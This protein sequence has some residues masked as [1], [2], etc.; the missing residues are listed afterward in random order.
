MAG[1]IS[2]AQANAVID[3]LFGASAAA[4]WL[5]IMVSAP[6]GDGSGGVEVT[7]G[8]YAR[9]AFTDNATTW[10]AAAARQ[11]KNGI[12]FTFPAPTADWG[13]NMW[14]LGVYD[15][16]TGGVPKGFFKFSTP[17]TILNGYPAFVV[18]AD[19]V[20]AGVFT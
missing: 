20:T 5:A 11:K 13:T 10:P 12:A 14:G 7:G 6:A 18:S 16:A 4:R 1:I 17:V 9:V 19:S 3:S 15:A 8:S 2:D